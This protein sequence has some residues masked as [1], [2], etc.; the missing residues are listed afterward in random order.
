MIVIIPL[1]IGIAAGCGWAL[2]TALHLNPHPREMLLAAIAC[3]IASE[4]AI[5]PLILARGRAQASVTQAALL[6]TIVHLFVCSVFAGVI[7]MWKSLHLDGAV[8]Y[9]LLSFYWLTLIV[10]AM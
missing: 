7:L 9:W 3:L 1:P 10:L 4:L 2:C 5:A 8:V 6:A